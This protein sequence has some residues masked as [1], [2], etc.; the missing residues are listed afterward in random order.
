MEKHCWT[1]ASILTFI[2]SMASLTKA[3]KGR[4]PYW[5]ACYTAADGRQLKK[6]TKETDRKKA[7]EVCLALERAEDLAK[8]G[9]L[10]ETRTRELLAE[11]LERTTGETLP[12]FTVEGF[13]RD[14]LNGK[15]VSK[16]ANTFRNY[17]QTVEGFIGH[18]GRRAKLSI[19]AI[20]AKDV[21]ELQRISGPIFV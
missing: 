15:E 21:S 10:T 2:R 17:T 5:I 7:L 11:V 8:K 19:A 20:T 9:T 6:S 14:W 1:S 18:L 3:S 16:A 12:F 13:L 4:S